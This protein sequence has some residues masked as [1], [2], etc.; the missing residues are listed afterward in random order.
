MGFFSFVDGVPQEAAVLDEVAA[1]PEDNFV[2]LKFVC[3]FFFD[4]ASHTARSQTS[5]ADLAELFGPI[6]CRPQDRRATIRASMIKPLSEMLITIQ[7]NAPTN[8]IYKLKD[9]RKKLCIA[10]HPYEARSPR[11]LTFAVGTVISVI[12][13][14]KSGW[15]KG[16]ITVNAHDDDAR[17]I[18]WF[19]QQFVEDYVP[20]RATEA[21]IVGGMVTL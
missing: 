9:D 21:L 14:D 4:V 20:G 19:P 6:F 10:M 18:G 16:A 1:L 7:R 8:I 3:R 17:S 15:W 13:K 12:K 2:L 11:E 5:V